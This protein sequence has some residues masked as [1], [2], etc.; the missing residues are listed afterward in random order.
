[1]GE[2]EFHTMKEH[3]AHSGG[4]HCLVTG[5]GG[6][7]GRYLVEQLVARGDTVRCFSRQAYPALEEMGVECV[8]GDLRNRDE[9]QLACEGV[10]T[11]FHCAAVPGVWGPWE[12]FHSINTTGTENVIDACRR[13]GVSRLVYTSSPSVVFDGHEHTDADES[14]PYPKEFLCHY[15]HTKMLGEQAAL[16]ANDEKL[17]TVSI[18]PHLI[19]GPR[20]NHLLPRLIQRARSGKLRRVGDGTN[21]VSVAYVEN[22]A[23]AH[24]QVANVLSPDSPAAGKAYFV[25]D[26]IPVRLW[27]WVD[28]F[29][30]MAGLPPVRKSISANAARRVG[31]AM[32]MVW[33]TLRLKS[34]PMMT[35]FIAAQLSQSHSYR[36]DNAINDFGYTPVCS[37]EDGLQRLQ[38]WIDA[39]GL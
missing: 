7:L 13:Q 27:D 39:E 36:I 23:A 3:R 14:L 28:Q 19:W 15:P 12:Y 11:V 2:D 5:G 31:R 33:G 17:S 16:S 25:N 10:D 26:P 18:R 32:E 1:M 29:L 37:V 20:D 24:L 6:F 35:R 22:A 38:E 34:E 8:R 9:V 30:G 4:K 21:E